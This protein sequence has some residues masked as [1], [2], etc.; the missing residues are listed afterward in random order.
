MELYVEPLGVD[1]FSQITYHNLIIAMVINL[2]T[3]LWLSLLFLLFSFF[4]NEK[5]ICF[6]TN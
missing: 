3:P 2:N 6:K 4:W 1:T 5:A